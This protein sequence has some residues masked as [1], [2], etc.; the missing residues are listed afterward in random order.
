MCVTAWNDIKYIIT[1][2]EKYTNYINGVPDE[3][4]IFY[5]EVN[6]E[7]LN[8][9]KINLLFN[10]RNNTYKYILRGDVSE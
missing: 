10:I 6:K 4:N 2:N 5:I 3:N 7:V 9:E 1:L 8:A